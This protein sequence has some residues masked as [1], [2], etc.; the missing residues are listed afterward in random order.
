MCR[1]LAVT[2]KEGVLTDDDIEKIERA[3]KDWGEVN[4][5]GT[6]IAWV[7]D[8]G[9]MKFEKSGDEASVF[10]RTR[11]LKERIGGNVK[12]LLGHVRL[13]CSGSS[14]AGAYTERGAHPFASCNQDFLLMHNGWIGSETLGKVTGVLNDNGAAC[15]I[16]S[17]PKGSNLRQGHHEMTSDVDSEYLTH[18]VE[19]VGFEKAIELVHAPDS[20]Y[21]ILMLYRDGSMKA[22]GDGSLIGGGITDPENRLTILA[23]DVTPIRYFFTGDMPQFPQLNDLTNYNVE[24]APNGVAS[25]ALMEEHTYEPRKSH[26][27][28]EMGKKAP[29]PIPTYENTTRCPRCR[30]RNPPVGHERVHKLSVVPSPHKQTAITNPVWNRGSYYNPAVSS[31]Y[32]KMEGR[33]ERYGGVRFSPSKTTHSYEWEGDELWEITKDE[34]GGVIGKKLIRVYPPTK[35]IPLARDVVEGRSPVTHPSPVNR[36]KEA[37]P[38]LPVPPRQEPIPGRGFQLSKLTPLEQYRERRRQILRRQGV[39]EDL[40]ESQ[41]S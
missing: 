38:P 20:K 30:M 2:A 13:S 18:L 4:R 8:D 5:H 15:P 29:T 28:K 19:Q 26:E 25:Y 31:R 6:G 41:L 33:E 37:R 21:N 22:H 11:S 12:T 3:L 1:M 23:S 35:A 36:P 9:Q 10:F 17:K 40:I 7:T 14:D 24:V 32:L 27:K 34:K 16:S 39:P